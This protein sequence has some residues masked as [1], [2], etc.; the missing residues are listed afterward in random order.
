MLI[1]IHLADY[2]VH[3][4]WEVLHHH[5][6]AG[7]VAIIPAYHARGPGIGVQWIRYKVDSLQIR[8]G[9]SIQTHMNT[10]TNLS[11]VDWQIGAPILCIELPL[12]SRIH[13]CIESSL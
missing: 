6:S 13:A 10:L 12:L 8:G 9:N 2:E 4:F 5:S 3:D 7:R 11:E 1:L